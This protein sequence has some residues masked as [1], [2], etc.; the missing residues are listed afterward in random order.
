MK[1]TKL[2][3]LEV[4]PNSFYRFLKHI[5]EQEVQGFKCV[6]FDHTGHK[7]QRKINDTVFEFNTYL[8]TARSVDGFE[9]YITIDSKYLP[10]VVYDFLEVTSADYQ[11]VISKYVDEL[12]SKKEEI[13]KA[14]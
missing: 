13:K 2:T 8:G 1:L 9:F 11:R 7:W 14:V 10:T 4:N 6:D 12:L 3:K 5:G